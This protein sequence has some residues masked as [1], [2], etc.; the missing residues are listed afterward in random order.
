MSKA[1][2]MNSQEKGKKPRRMKEDD[3][4]KTDRSKA[5]RRILKV[6]AI[7]IIIVILIAIPGFIM[8]NF[9][10]NHNENPDTLLDDKEVLGMVIK[11][12]K[13]EDMDGLK[14]FKAIVEN[15][16]NKK[17]EQKEVQIVF[18]DEKSQKINKYPYV[19]LD[20]EKG[21]TQEI[22]IKTSEPLDEFYNFD[23]IY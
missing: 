23:I 3:T 15:T 4:K 13:I 21:E 12:I 16:S 5:K 9:E 10:N 22:I 20:L 14:V 19:I 18:R 17:F 11:D 8:M 1:K 7:I 6:F 2:R